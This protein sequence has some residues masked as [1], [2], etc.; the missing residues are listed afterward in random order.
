MRKW[1][2]L[3]EEVICFKCVR[4]PL[5]ESAWAI[6]TDWN[7]DQL[8]VLHDVRS[9]VF[10]DSFPFFPFSFVRL[11][12]WGERRGKKCCLCWVL[13]FF[14]E[15]EDWRGGEWRPKREEVVFL[16]WGNLL[17]TAKGHYSIL[18]TER[19]FSGRVETGRVWITFKQ[20]D[21]EVGRCSMK[22]GRERK[23]AGVVSGTKN[24]KKDPPHA[25]LN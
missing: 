9:V 6:K 7:Q 5:F 2:S 24:I 21:A 25:G 19:S 10:L 11:L 1:L 23:T 12:L 18:A 22:R 20:A 8:A 3:H 16:P 13:G 4:F 15:R 14:W 17:Q